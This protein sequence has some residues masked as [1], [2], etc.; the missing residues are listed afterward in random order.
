MMP[1]F[2]LGAAVSRRGSRSLI[3]VML[4]ATVL[5]RAMEAITQRILN[6]VFPKNHKY[7]GRSRKPARY[8]TILP[9][10]MIR[11]AIELAASESRLD[12]KMVLSGKRT[13]L[14][15]WSTV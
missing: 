13:L 1:P 7:F 4:M 9:K 6:W 8:P 2:V 12:L 5:P 11:L 15:T 14:M 3:V 10:P